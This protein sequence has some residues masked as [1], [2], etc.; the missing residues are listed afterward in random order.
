MSLLRSVHLL[1]QAAE[2]QEKGRCEE[3]VRK[4]REAESTFMLAVD[5]ALERLGKA[6]HEIVAQTAE[7]A[8]RA[9]GYRV[10]R[11]QERG[12]T[13]LRATSAGA[14]IGVVVRDA[15]RLLI[16]AAGFEGAACRPVIS[17]FFDRLR[18]EGVYVA[19]EVGHSHRHLEGGA[20]LSGGSPD[21]RSLLKASAK[22]ES[23]PEGS[24]KNRAAED[25]RLALRLRSQGLLMERR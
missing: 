22:L 10:E 12:R 16:E 7:D 17:A 21:A 9:L 25:R 13:A 19:P 24:A 11:A 23:E 5:G 8:L 4:A 2:D 1:A 15:G 18:K 3:A 6:Q 20:L 14:V